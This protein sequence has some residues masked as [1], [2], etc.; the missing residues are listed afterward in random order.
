MSLVFRHSINADDH[1]HKH[2]VVAQNVISLI[3]RECNVHYKC[4]P[5]M[6]THSAIVTQ[7]KFCG[8]NARNCV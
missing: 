3:V 6:K 7:T 8:L 1:N 2:Y 4:L 5:P